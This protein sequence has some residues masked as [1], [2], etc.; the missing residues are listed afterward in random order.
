MDL[1]TRKPH[2]GLVAALLAGASLVAVLLLAAPASAQPHGIGNTGAVFTATNAASDNAVLAFRRN[3][4]GRLTFL[5]AYLTGGDGSGSGLGNQ[6]ALTLN[7]D[8]DRLLVVNAGSDTVSVFGIEPHGLTLLDQED[9]HGTT[10]ISVTTYGGLVYV[11]NAGGDGNIAGFELADDGTLS[12]LMGSDKPLSGA[13]AGP[14]QIG[15][16]PDG[17]VLAV[18]EKAANSIVTYLV[19]ND[20]LPSDPIVNT[21]EGSTPF[22]FDFGHRGRLLVSEAAGGAFEAATA[23]SYEVL[24]DGYLEFITSE[25]PL[26]QS[27]ACWLVVTGNGRYAYT[28][29]TGSDSVSGIAVDRGGHLS[30]LQS[31]GKSADAGDAPIDAAFSRNSRFLYVLNGGDDTLSAYEVGPDGSL[32]PISGVMMGLPSSTNGLAAF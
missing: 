17:S 21:S 22:G 11:L 9:S 31:S 23:S 12:F 18:T 27:A 30:L 2:R 32:S 20:G 1:S 19:G 7:E 28:T 14:A 15:F 10:P 16:S 13:G 8:A 24:P 25:L 3:A 5:D 26:H 29:N 6:S 4:Q